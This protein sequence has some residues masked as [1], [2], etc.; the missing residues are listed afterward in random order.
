MGIASPASCKFVIEACSG[1][2]IEVVDWV[3]VNGKSE[4]GP[5]DLDE[6]RGWTRLLH[7]DPAAMASVEEGLHVA[8]LIESILE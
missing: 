8:N 4:A 7:G 1:D 6:A 2:T 5:D 3:V